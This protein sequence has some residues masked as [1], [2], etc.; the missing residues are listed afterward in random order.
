MI[1]EHGTEQEMKEGLLRCMDFTPQAGR[2]LFK[3]PGTFRW[4]EIFV[5]APHQTYK[6][7]LGTKRARRKFIGLAI[8][9]EFFWGYYY[10]KSAAFTFIEWYCRCAEGRLVRLVQGHD[11]G[12]WFVS[13]GARLCGRQMEGFGGR[14]MVTGRIWPACGSPKLEWF[15]DGIHAPTGCR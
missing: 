15:R 10:G 9:Y 3:K 8:N 4:R 1:P 11:E 2:Y 12:R 5:R 14:I 7:V 13:P 6:M